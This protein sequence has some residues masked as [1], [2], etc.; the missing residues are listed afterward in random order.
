MEKYKIHRKQQST[1]FRTTKKT[2]IRQGEKMRF[3]NSE[4]D[5]K[6]Y[7]KFLEGH[8]R[9]NFQQSLEWAEVKKPNWQPEVILAEGN[10]RF[11]MCINS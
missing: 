1:L 7:K 8:E 5:K 2:P 11:T 9:G 10:N 4:E 3:V 6:E